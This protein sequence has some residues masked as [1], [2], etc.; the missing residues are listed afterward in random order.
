M[1]LEIWGKRNGTSNPKTEKEAMRARV[2][3]RLGIG[4][5]GVYSLFLAG[6]TVGPKYV[7]PSLRRL[8]LTRS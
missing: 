3:V 4:V 8:P 7:K 5:L 2:V 6:C 1:R